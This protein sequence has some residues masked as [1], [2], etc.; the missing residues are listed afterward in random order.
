MP[1]Y[2]SDD[3]YTLRFHF[4]R[5]IYVSDPL[6]HL[7]LLLGSK[8]VSLKLCFEL[9][10]NFEPETQKASTVVCFETSHQ[11]SFIIQIYFTG[12]F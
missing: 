3:L 10:M 1:Q 11:A 12:L 2:D 8:Y 6:A 9:K 7:R 5:R 4:N